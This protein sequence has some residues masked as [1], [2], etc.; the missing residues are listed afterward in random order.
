MDCSGSKRW[1]GRGSRNAG[2]GWGQQ[3]QASVLVQLCPPRWSALPIQ[4]MII[5]GRGSATGHLLISLRP[6][7]SN[8]MLFRATRRA[9]WVLLSTPTWVPGGGGL[10]LKAG[11]AIETGKTSRQAGG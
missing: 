7:T 1:R 5:D 10:R 8:R 2:G 11:R 9:C 4:L 6:L 3:G